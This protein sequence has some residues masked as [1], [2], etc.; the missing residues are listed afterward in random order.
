V[1]ESFRLDRKIVHEVRVVRGSLESAAGGTVRAAV[2]AARR[3][4]TE[5]NHS[6][7]HLVHEALRRVLGDHLHQ[8]GSHVAPDRLRFDFNHFQKIT[9]DQLS[10][11]E[12]MVNEKI[13]LAV[14]VN[15]LNDPKDWVTIDDAKRRY[16]NVKMFFGDKYGDRVRIVEIDPSFSVELCGGTH[17]ANSR[18]IGIFKIVSESGIASGIRRIEAVTGDGVRRHVEERLTRA[19]VLDDHLQQLL[20]EVASLE[21]QLGREPAA[22]E[23]PRPLEVRLDA[24]TPADVRGVD[25]AV[26]TREADAGLAA[27]ALNALRKDWSRVRV[28][29]AA[30]GIDDLVRQAGRVEGITLVSARV[31]AGSMDELKQLGDALRA[32]LHSGVGV[33]GAVIDGK[34]ALVAVVTDDLVRG[35]RLQAGAIVGAVARLVGGGGGGRPHLATAGGKDAGALDGALAQ[36]TGIVRTAVSG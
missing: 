35:G 4:A 28:K 15:A 3:S 36:V 13:A 20:E 7:T 33:L 34:A 24:L 18:E 31:D 5:R 1:L 30:G 25:E 17:V 14:R 2:D 26:A 10:A 19:K 29:S 23:R 16:P 21:K 9:P 6:A 22:R 32:R 11:I 27:E 12:E 8:Q